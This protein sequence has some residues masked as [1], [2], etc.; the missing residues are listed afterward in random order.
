LFF[1]EIKRVWDSLR[2]LVEDS[3]LA[4][5]AERISTFRIMRNKNKQTNKQTKQVERG[6]E[7]NKQLKKM[8]G[9]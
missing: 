6:V 8:V 5:I 1:I 4:N 2:G 9:E 3:F 7:T